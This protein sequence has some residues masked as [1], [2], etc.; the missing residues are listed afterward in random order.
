MLD[1]LIR[2]P[3]SFFELTPTGRILNLFSRDIYVV[4]Q[5]LARV[6]QNTWR[7]LTATLF[8][9]IVIGSSFPLFLL[10]IIPLGWFYLRVMKFVVCFLIP[11]AVLIGSIDIISPLLVSSNVWTLSADP[12]YLPGSVKVWLD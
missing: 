10:S 5:I 1:A 11:C 2:A 7:T 8:I 12:P 9:I 4:D 3:L 6:F